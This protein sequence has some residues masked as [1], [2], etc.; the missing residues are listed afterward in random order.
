MKAFMIYGLAALLT[1][2]SSLSTFAQ[3]RNDLFERAPWNVSAGLG[4]AKFEGDEQVQDGEY[5]SLKLGYDF[6]PRLTLEFG[7]DYAPSL[8]PNPFPNE[9]E[10]RLLDSSVYMLRLGADVLLHLRNTEDLR[11]DPFLSAGAKFVNWQEALENGKNEL[12]VA[13][14]GGMFYHF[15]DA[16]ALRGDAQAV[17]AGQNTEFNLYLGLGVNYRWGTVIPA[18]YQ[19][20]GGD[21]DSDGDGLLDSREAEIGTDPYNA[22][23]DGDG[24]LDGQEVDTYQT[25]PLNPDTDMDA[26]KDGAEVLTFKT[27]PLNRDTDNGGVADGHEVIEDGTDPLDP[28]DDLDLYT[29]NIEFDYNK[30]VLRPEYH[31]D[32]DVVLK[33]LSRDPEA[34]A[35]IEGHA[36]KRP[37][38]KRVYNQKL[39]ERRAQA[40]M[41]Y[42]IQVGGIETSRLS[43]V[44]YGFDRPVAPNDTE[45]NMQKNRRTEIYIRSGSSDEGDADARLTE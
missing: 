33:V 13:V 12:T 23:T 9:P 40:V 3:G 37:T 31:E 26:L 20:S 18:A 44:G 34:E 14:G 5:V 8:D 36:D 17:V 6:N 19:V 4:L 39:S 21:V 24:L 41:D 27:D 16:W 15:N 2:L 25:D 29:L 38:S 30:A 32:L 42:L 43:A 7:L 22:D 10:R 11:F 28:A 1:G 35:R 45:E